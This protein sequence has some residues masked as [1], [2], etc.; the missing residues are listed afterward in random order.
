L[1]AEEASRY[2]HNLTD[3]V[4][5]LSAHLRQEEIPGEA[6]DIEHPPSRTVKK[7]YTQI[8]ELREQDRMSFESFLTLDKH[9]R[10]LL[11]ACGASERILQT[12][13]PI[14]YYALLRQG[15]TVYLLLTPFYLH[16]EMMEAGLILYLV[17]VYFLVGGEIALSHLEELFERHP[18]GI[19]NQVIS[20]RLEA[21]IK[22]VMVDQ[23]HKQS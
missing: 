9:L 8:H 18:D 17:L 5:Q 19:K 21:Y 2:A 3:F 7:L 1:T 20:D 22:D 15:I 6:G 16:L 12:R 4:Q 10:G 14:S 11:D 23:P 13:L